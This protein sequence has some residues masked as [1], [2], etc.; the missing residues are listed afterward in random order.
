MCRMSASRGIEPERNLKVG[1]W[2]AE[3]KHFWNSKK[4]FLLFLRSYLPIVAILFAFSIISYGVAIRQISD[5]V[6]R[7]NNTLMDNIRAS[8]DQHLIELEKTS[9]RLNSQGSTLKL[10]YL[11][12]GNVDFYYEMTNYVRNLWTL[13]LENDAL[14]PRM[15]IYFARSGIVAAPDTFYDSAEFYGNVFQY[16]G[17]SANEFYGMLLEK[18]N[19]FRYLPARR[20]ILQ[21]SVSMQGSFEMMIYN[22]QLK[23]VSGSGAPG[24]IFF[25][26]DT[27][28]IARMLG[29]LTIGSDGI[30]AVLDS[31]GN[32]VARLD[33]G[34]G[35][36]D[37]QIRRTADGS[38][39]FVRD[40]L[41][42]RAVSERNGW[43]Y[44]ALGGSDVLM[45]PV[46]FLRKILAGLFGL[47]LLLALAL[48]AYMARKRSRPLVDL[49]CRLNRG[50]YPE[51]GKAAEGG[52]GYGLLE[53]GVS[54]MLQRN[55][56][57]EGQLEAIRPMLLPA[58]L[59][60]LFGGGFADDA[61]V[62]SAAEE[63]AIP[64]PPG[65]YRLVSFNRMQDGTHFAELNAGV[66]QMLK[67]QQAVR[68]CIAEAGFSDCLLYQMKAGETIWIYQGSSGPS[69]EAGLLEM[70]DR[71]AEWMNR[72]G[73]KMLIR[74]SREFTILSNAW[75]EYERISLASSAGTGGLSR[76]MVEMAWH[77]PDP[78]QRQYMLLVEPILGSSF[79]SGDE[80]MLSR[81]LDIVRKEVF[82]SAHIGPSARKVL[83]RQ[84]RELARRLTGK[85]PEFPSSPD[86]DSEQLF[87]AVRELL[88][89]ACREAT[90]SRG[91]AGSFLIR[92]I[93]EYTD[94]ELYNPML[95][96]TMIATKMNISENYLSRVFKE[97]SGETLADYIESGRI[98]AAQQLLNDTMM[99][100]AD[101]AAKVGYNSDHVF[102]RAF[103]RVTGLSPI[104]YRQGI[105]AAPGD[106]G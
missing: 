65:P 103:R 62:A 50:E 54:S 20:I 85:A 69:D 36:T 92:K 66:L 99:S 63:M 76:S 10:T 19:N 60:R 15:Y 43:K 86:Y 70:L 16:Q 17:F 28:E 13:W 89:D 104:E 95:S 38:L 40:R 27:R 75:W 3:T 88:L 39:E 18:E 94:Q 51:E 71:F 64:L 32:I 4:L 74:F 68:D 11:D 106:S 34:S 49:V 29:D 46:E 26:I 7:L 35:L 9:H 5:N 105:N 44:L 12:K 77:D 25:L 22:Y 101:I 48:S 42:I 1:R 56:D 61:E 102:R 84:F 53:Y 47:S 87:D 6:N 96:M 24:A 30:A 73:L 97:Q 23:Q 93:R 2:L 78:E 59:H 14:T 98:R 81:L 90:R 55:D 67:L 45:K 41:A 37:E 8:I 83:A 82:E 91:G 57:M 72:R 79:R 33:N 100:I 80:R 21:D 52:T 31:E 58:F